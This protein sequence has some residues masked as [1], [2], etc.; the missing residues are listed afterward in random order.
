MN[1]YVLILHDFGIICFGFNIF[2]IYIY[3]ATCIDFRGLICCKQGEI[4]YGTNFI[5]ISVYEKN[6]EKTCVY[7]CEDGFY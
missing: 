6:V 2:G 4:L 5:L 1:K 3:K 7:A